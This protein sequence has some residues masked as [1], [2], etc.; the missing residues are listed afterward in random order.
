VFK[1]LAAWGKSA[2]CW[3]FGFKLYLIINDQGELLAFQISP[4]NL[5]DRVPVPSLTQKI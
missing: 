3:Y 1:D 2:I 5:D 4:G